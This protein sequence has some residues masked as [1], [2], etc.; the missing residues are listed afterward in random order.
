MLTIKNRGTV[1]GPTT[2]APSFG[3]SRPQSIGLL[4]FIHSLYQINPRSLIFLLGFTVALLTG[5][6]PPGP[7][8]LL[9]GKKL[10]EQG[11]YAQA[12][13]TLRTATSLLTTNAQAWNY[14]GLANHH[15]GQPAEAE[16]AYQRALRLDPDLTEAHY[17]LGCL[18]LEQNKPSA[19]RTEFT[20]YTLRRGDSVDAL[21]KLGAA[22]LRTRDYAAAEKSFGEALRLSPQNPEALN[23]LGCTRAQRG[24]AAEAAQFFVNAIKL[25]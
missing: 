22:Q 7:R 25:K 19:A 11:K 2:G 24:R 6:T 8:A 21:L 4:I 20:A 5:C 14:Y 13:E 12:V 10:I 18:L 23:G 1:P 3:K 9:Q 15:S 16:Q 17:N